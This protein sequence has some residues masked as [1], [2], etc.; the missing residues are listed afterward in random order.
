MDSL[1]DQAVVGVTCLCRAGRHRSVAMS[2]ILQL[3]MEEVFEVTVVHAE[4]GSWGSLC[5]T[6]EDCVDSPAKQLAIKHHIRA[7][8]E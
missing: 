3:V 6:C 8:F 7:A 2:Y 5:T 1:T 4:H